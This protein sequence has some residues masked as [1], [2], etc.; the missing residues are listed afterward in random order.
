[1]FELKGKK[2]FTI[3]SIFFADLG[4]LYLEGCN[5]FCSFDFCQGEFRLHGFCIYSR[6]LAC[7]CCPEN[8]K[9]QFTGHHS[10]F[11]QNL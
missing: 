8:C 3:L 11:K 1:M 10:Y 5:V 2:I 7:T 9:L 4:L 6:E